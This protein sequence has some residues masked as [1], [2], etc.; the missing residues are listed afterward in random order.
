V[1]VVALLLWRIAA[2][3]AAV[4]QKSWRMQR[5]TFLD[6]TDWDG[7][8]YPVTDPQW[9]HNVAKSIAAQVEDNAIIFTDWSILYD[10]Y[11][12][13]HVEHGRTGISV[14][15]T[16]PAMTPKPFAVSAR[17]YIKDNY[18]KRPIYFTLVEDSRLL[19]DYKFVQI[20]S[21][22]PLYRLEKR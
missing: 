2:P 12:A 10:I 14:H 20:D 6:G 16:Y 19:L 18:G 15:E 9:P 7:Y 5:I 1:L 22:I 8:P 13:T 3:S 11:Y 21:S 17:Q 4:V